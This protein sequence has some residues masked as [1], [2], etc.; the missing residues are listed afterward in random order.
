M[1]NGSLLMNYRTAISN[2]EK[3]LEDIYSTNNSYR[4]EYEGY[5]INLKD[6]ERIK[7]IVDDNKVNINDSENNLKINQLM[8]TFGN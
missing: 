5:L 3:Y 8:M 6:Y 4:R 1:I 2:F 7:D